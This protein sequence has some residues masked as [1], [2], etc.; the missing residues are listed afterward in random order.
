VAA[1]QPEDSTIRYIVN[2]LGC[3]VPETIPIVQ[4]TTEE[5]LLSK[6]SSKNNIENKSSS[7][8]TG[9]NKGPF[10]SDKDNIEPSTLEKVKSQPSNQGDTSNSERPREVYHTP[11]GLE[12][13][14]VLSAEWD[15]SNCDSKQ[16]STISNLPLSHGIKRS[17]AL[18]KRD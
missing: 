14:I 6:S 12:A 16:I 8:A 15:C 13:D 10:A 18:A 7:T 11:P 3:I 4:D 1:S 5:E 9:F 17:K 2:E